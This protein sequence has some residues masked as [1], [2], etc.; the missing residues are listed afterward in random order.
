MKKNIVI[1]ICFLLLVTSFIIFQK[2]ESAAYYTYEPITEEVEISGAVTNPGKYT[3]TKD[4][5]LA[6]LINLAGGLKENADISNIRLGEKL[7]KSHYKIESYHVEINPII[8][9]INLNEAKLS[10]LLKI[11]NITETRA[12]QILIYKEINGKFKNVNEL[13][14]IKG[15]GEATFEKIHIYF[16]V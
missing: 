14:N 12:T 2:D 8:Q 1:T 7:S 11:P 4:M 5:T 9:K 6:Y 15:I 3:V 13:L 10:D 16:Y